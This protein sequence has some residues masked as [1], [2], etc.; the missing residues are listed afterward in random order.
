[1]HPGEAAAVFLTY[2]LLRSLRGQIMGTGPIVCVVMAVPGTYCIK[3]G[4][5]TEQR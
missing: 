1:M 5:G 4:F 3:L 2:P